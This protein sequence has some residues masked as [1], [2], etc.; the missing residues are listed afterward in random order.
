MRRKE[1][2]TTGQVAKICHVAPRTVSK[3]FDSGKLR[4]YRIPGSRDRRIPLTHL[5]RFMRTHGMPLRE[6]EG[7]TLRILIVDPD[8]SAEA[9][10]E[11]LSGSDRYEIR[12]ASNDF[13]AGML[14]GEFEPHV[15]LVNA[16]N[17]DIDARKIL[18]NLRGNPNLAATKVVAMAGP[19]TA[20]QRQRVLEE[21]YDLLLCQPYELR[22]VVRIIEKATDLLA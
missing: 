16:A 10:A 4:G 6:L 17:G 11:D 1:V 5:L 7:H 2:L 15:M 9:I 19:L 21:G 13:E 14:A 20:D 12:T 22:D 8:D 18:D 3:W